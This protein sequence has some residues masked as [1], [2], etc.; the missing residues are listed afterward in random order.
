M[1]FFTWSDSLS[2]QVPAMDE[3]HKKLFNLINQLHDAMARREGNTVIKPIL[4][5]LTDYTRTHFTS[6]EVFLTS[7]KYPDLHKQKAEHVIFVQ[8]LMDMQ[9]KAEKSQVGLTIEIMDFLKDWLKNHI[10]IEDKKYAA[11]IAKANVKV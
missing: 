11:A 2:V 8:K 4:T 1:A 10:M 7:I 6:E 9:L 3:Q 5:A